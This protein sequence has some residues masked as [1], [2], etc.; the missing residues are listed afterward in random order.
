ME[1]AIP[2]FPLIS[3]SIEGYIAQEGDVKQLEVH[4]GDL[5]TIEITINFDL[6]PKD[7]K[8]ERGYIHS[9]TFPYMKKDNYMVIIT[10]KDASRIFNL[11][12]LF[13]RTT[14][15]TWKMQWRPQD[16][17]DL[18]LVIHIKNDSYKGLD[19]VKHMPIKILPEV[20]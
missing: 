18:E 12:R 15:H 19:I 16:V 13:F 2:V 4:S 10:N 5:M 6:Y 17:M 14:S 8:A 3:A 20:A 11:E 7:S 9:N 1:K